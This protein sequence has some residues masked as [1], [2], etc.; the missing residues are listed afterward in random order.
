MTDKNTEDNRIRVLQVLDKCAMRGAP[1]HG[2]SRL[3]LAWWPEFNETDVDLSLCVLRGESGCD[4]FSKT[5]VFVEDLNRGKMDLRTVFD[6]I[7]IIR[8]DRIQILHCHGYGATTF[9]RIAGLLTGTPVIVHEHMV[10]VNIPLYQKIADKLLSPFTAKGVAVSNAV[11]AFMT[12]PRS[13]S[14][15]RM[16]VIYNCVPSE[17]CVPF[18]DKQ[19]EEIAER[20][21]V[22]RDKAIVGIVGRLDPVKGHVDFLSAAKEVLKAVPEVCF[23]IVG[24]GELR[25]ELERYTQQLG[26]QDNVLFLGHCENVKEIVSL[27]DLL[28]SSSLSEGLPLNILEAMA[29]SKPVVATSVGGIPEVVEDGKNG[30]LVPVNSVGALADKITMLLSDDEL[31]DKFGKNA[32]EVCEKSY[33]APV[34][35]SQLIQLYKELL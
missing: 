24:E 8:R 3:L 16:Q 35:V 20:Y 27:F 26:I 13:I 30:F 33:L 23:V 12:G 4:D 7:R 29:Q 6:L 19:K 28:A 5:G 1:I 18:S 25:P 10:D 17:Y 21:N 9:G 22:P 32:L 34:S 2:V 15:Q 31:R 14:K 11:N